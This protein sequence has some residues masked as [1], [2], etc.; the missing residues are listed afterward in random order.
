M[1]WAYPLTNKAEI[2]PSKTH[3][4]TTFTMGQR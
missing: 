1:G 4:L 3:Y 2:S